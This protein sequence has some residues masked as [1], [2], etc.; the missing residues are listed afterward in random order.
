MIALNRVFDILHFTV[1]MPI[2]WLDDNTHNVGYQGC[3]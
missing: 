1:C 3:D 2:L